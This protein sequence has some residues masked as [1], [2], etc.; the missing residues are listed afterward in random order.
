[1][2]HNLELYKSGSGNTLYYGGGINRDCDYEEI[3]DGMIKEYILR[4]KAKGVPSLLD[5][6]ED[7]FN[8]SVPGRDDM[9]FVPVDILLDLNINLG[10]TF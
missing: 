10:L 4:S 8:A 3:V 9:I 6:I 5:G 1:M 2:L 7:Q